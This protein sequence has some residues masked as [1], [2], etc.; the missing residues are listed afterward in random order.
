VLWRTAGCNLES[1]RRRMEIGMMVK[2]II[3]GSI[4]TLLLSVSSLAAAC[5]LSC[6]FAGADSDC[7][8]QETPFQDSANAG[9]KMDGMDMAGMTMPDT[10]KGETQQPDS[11]ISSPTPGHPAIGEMGACEKQ[12]C[13][14]GPAIS[15]KTAR[16]VD[17]QIHSL[18]AF[19]EAPGAE[20][21][22]PFLYEARDDI[23]L[24]RRLDVNPL[25][26]TLRI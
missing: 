6:A 14:D 15:A 12:P 7:H 22:L 25:Q 8:S 10:S 21:S 16:F 17:S 24:Y 18:V 9:M 1:R 26:L 3:A 5:D 23:A 11:A 20:V 4:V 19:I 2:R 13:Y